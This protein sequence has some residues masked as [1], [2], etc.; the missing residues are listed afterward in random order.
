MLEK[1]SQSPHPEADSVIHNGVRFEQVHDEQTEPNEVG[2]IF[3]D[4]Y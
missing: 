3:G 4:N 1:W 2:A